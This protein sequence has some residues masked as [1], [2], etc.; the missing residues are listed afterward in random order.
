MPSKL[1]PSRESIKQHLVEARRLRQEAHDLDPEHKCW[2]WE[3]EDKETGPNVNTHK[4]L[5]AFYAQVLD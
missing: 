2:A 1:N 4:A 3:A 5:M